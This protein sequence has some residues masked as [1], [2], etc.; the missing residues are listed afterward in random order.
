M[1]IK[2]LEKKNN[3]GLVICFIGT[4]GSGKSTIID[5]IKPSLE[6]KFNGGVYY[7]HLRPNYLPSIA[8]IFRRSVSFNEPVV[9][10]HSS[11]QSGFLVSFVRWSYYMLDYT[12]GYFIKVFPK[13]KANSCVWVFDRYYY[14]Y[15]IDP[16]R[17]RVKLPK[18]IL[19][20]GQFII[21][22]PDIIICLGTDPQII[23]KRKPE[24]QLD[25]VKRQVK[26]LKIFCNDHKRS[27]WIDTGKSIETSSLDAFEEIM[28][29][30]NN[31][32]KNL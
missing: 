19:K 16:I 20:F 29:C 17:L 14:D 25:E 10:P 3:V 2:S 18:L 12:L 23:H 7:E 5:T 31:K 24:L 13:L 21:S 26:E 30:Y 6:T 4:D 8:S 15:F 11:P 28:L 1:T 22:E 27:I 9:D 32:I